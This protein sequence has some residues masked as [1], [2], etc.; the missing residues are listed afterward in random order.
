MDLAP[1]NAIPLFFPNATYE[2]VYFEAVANALDAG[3]S[4]IK[5]KIEIEEFSKPET[6]EVTIT[7]NGIGFTDERFCRFVELAEPEDKYHKGLG[8]L[9]YL[10]YFSEVNFE[11]QYDGKKRS[12]TFSNDF[13]NS[14]QIED[15]AGGTGTSLLFKKFCGQ[16]VKSYDDLKPQSIKT[17]LLEQFFPLFYDMKKNNSEFKITVQLFTDVNNDTYGFFPDI[18]SITIED[19]PE[20][21]EETFDDTTSLFGDIQMYSKVESNYS[22]KSLISSICVDGR[23]L[24]FDLVPTKS[25]PTGYKAIFLFQSEAFQ[26]KVDESRQ[27]LRLSNDKGIEQQLRGLLRSKV[28]EVLVQ[29][30]PEILE[31]NNDVKQQFNNRYPHLT[32]YFDEETVGLIDKSESLESAQK[33]FF[34]AQKEILECDTLND[35]QFDKSLEISSRLLTEYI[36]YRTLIIKKLKEMTPKNS[37]ADIHNLIVPQR[38]TYQGN[39]AMRDLY[40]NNAWLLDDKY[41][42]YRTILSEAR[43]DAVMEAI[44][45]EDEQEPDN[46]RPDITL[47]FSD[48]PEITPKVD[49]IIVELKKQGLPLAKNEEVVSQLRQRARKLL[50]HFPNKINRIWFYGITDIDTEFRI[51]LKEDGFKQLYSSDQLFYKSQTIIID[52]E[53][54]TSLNA[55]LYVMSYDALVNDAEARN[56]TFLEVLKTGLQKFGKAED[57]C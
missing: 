38:N 33:E 36:L 19:I 4:E 27:N 57:M 12:F 37:E 42:V 45:F 50:K 3:A 15:H 51:S 10:K 11:S 39:N 49:V 34:K 25:L 55:D 9:V 23:A 18:Q 52:D 6:L 28:S 8:R 2:Q 53:A 16:K 13:K 21:E 7:D 40:E 5:I 54:D 20:L 47:I 43:M 56:K 30:V 14:S 46:R 31:R 44:T 1:K 22:G 35:A 41:M 29:Q 17:S 24:P 26:G 32:G 48:D